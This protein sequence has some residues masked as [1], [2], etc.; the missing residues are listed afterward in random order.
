[1]ILYTRKSRVLSKQQT[2]LTFLI[3]VN[4][5]ILK[6][7][8][9]RFVTVNI[10]SVCYLTV[11]YIRNVPVRYENTCPCWLDGKEGRLSILKGDTLFEINMFTIAVLILLLLVLI[12]KL[13]KQ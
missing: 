12:Y 8:N 3:F 9:S 13:P 11:C 2:D 1:M 6:I 7:T 5:K 10:H 4:V